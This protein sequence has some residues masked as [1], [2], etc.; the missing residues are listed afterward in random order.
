MTTREAIPAI[1]K[2]FDFSIQ[3]S[4]C[5]EYIYAANIPNIIL[6][7]L[8]MVIFLGVELISSKSGLKLL[9]NLR[10]K[11]TRIN[12]DMLK[13]KEVFNFLIIKSDRNKISGN[14]V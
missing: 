7:N 5:L 12:I 13:N 1:V 9:K 4:L 8:K 14:K 6:S 10:A 11:G 2:N 3:N